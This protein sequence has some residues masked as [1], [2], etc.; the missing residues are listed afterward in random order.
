MKAYLTNRFVE[1]LKP[2]H[3]LKDDFYWDEGFKGFGVKVSKNGCKSYVLQKGFRSPED[4]ISHSFRVTL[5]KHGEIECKEARELAAV[6]LAY[7]IKNLQT[8][9]KKPFS[10]SIKEEKKKI[11]SEAFQQDELSFTPPFD[12]FCMKFLE[13][14]TPDISINTYINYECCIRKRLI[15]AFQKTPLDKITKKS[16]IDLRNS[17]SNVPGQCALVISLLRTM[18]NHAFLLGYVK[19]D[20]LNGITTHWVKTK[21]RTLSEKELKQIW[22]YISDASE[23]QAKALQVAMLTG[24]RITEILES[25]WDNISLSESTWRFP[26]FTSKTNSSTCIALTNPLKEILVAQRKYYD[27]LCRTPL[28]RKKCPYIFFKKRHHI[29]KES[30][31]RYMLTSQMI[32]KYFKEVL[33][34]LGLSSEFTTHDLRHAFASLLANEGVPMAYVQKALGHTHGRTTEKYYTHFKNKE[35]SDQAREAFS[36]IL[37]GRS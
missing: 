8:A 1:N 37:L 34:K 9:L 25:T 19:A 14:K 12:E 21:D 20:L 5:G 30:E 4:G 36:D 24:I 6:K 31:E 2:S 35:I 16:I 32:L 27:L 3:A 28:T 22:D 11:F 33:G 10:R 13:I 26:S 7:Y 23:P 17:M 18:L 29:S 15:P